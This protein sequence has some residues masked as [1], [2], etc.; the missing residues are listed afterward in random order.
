[1]TTILSIEET[2]DRGRRERERTGYPEGFPVLPPVPAG[3]YA[4][5]GFAALEREYVFD[6]SWLFV[7]HTDELAEPGDYVLLRQLPKPVLLVRGHDGTIRAMLNSCQHRGGPVVPDDAGN[8]GRRLVCGYHAWTYDLDG[9]LVGLPGAQDFQVDT[10]C[11]GL[12]PVRCE[13]WGSL[14]F[15][16]LDSDAPPLLDALGVV[17][18]ELHDQIGGGDGVGPVHLVGRRSIE[19]DGN[20]KLTVDANIETYHVNTVHRTSAAVVLD[21]AA[22]GIFLFPDGH[23]HMLVHSRDG[24]AFPIDLPGFPGASPLANCGIYSFHLFPNTSIVFGGSPALAFLISSWP[25]GPD[26]SLYDVH[27]LAATPADGPHGPLLA[28]LVEANWAVLLEDLANL[29][30]IQRSVESGGLTAMTLSY[31]ERR[32]YHQHEE[33]D[34]RIGADLVPPALRVEPVLAG[35]TEA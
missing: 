33:L 29:A 17:G 30:A 28:A 12:P 18:R 14:V 15:V 4:D 25:V 3:R 8:T 24:K 23:S 31:Q 34:R 1:M 7:A 26:R 27:F 10:A 9:T 16:N 2:L 32:I 13:V 11:L 35:R 21:Q 20:W 5:A 19:V 22:T 6:K